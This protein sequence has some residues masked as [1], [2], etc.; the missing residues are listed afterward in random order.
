MTTPDDLDHQELAGL[1][2]AR[3]Y[4]VRCELDELAYFSSASAVP[5]KH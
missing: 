4:G 5:T 3:I 1:G 2:A